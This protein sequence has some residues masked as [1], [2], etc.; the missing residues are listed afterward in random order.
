MNYVAVG[1]TLSPTSLTIEEG[2]TKT[3][4]VKLTGQP[5]KDRTVNLSSNNSDVTVDVDPDTTGNQTT[6]TFTAENWNAEQ[7]VTVAAAHDTD[8]TDDTA[9]ISLTGTGITAGTVTVNVADDEAVGLTLSVTELKMN[10][11]STATFTVKLAEQFGDRTLTLQSSNSDVIVDTD[12]STKGNQAALTF[13]A[14][15]WNTAKTVTLTAAE[16]DDGA[17]DSATI[18]LTGDRITTVPLK[19]TV[20]DN[21]RELIL[22]ETLLRLT[23]GESG[24]FRVKLSH[25][26]PKNVTVT[27]TQP[28]NTDVTVDTDTIKAGN[29]NTLLFTKLNWS[30]YQTVQVSAAADLDT[31]NE[32]ASILLT[33]V[34][35]GFVT[36]TGTVT[37]KVKD[38]PFLV[39]T[40]KLTLVEGTSVTFTVQLGTPPSQGFFVTEDF[41]LWLNPAFTFDAD[42]DTPGNQTNLPFTS[43]NWSTPQTVTVRAAHDTNRTDE[44]GILYVLTLDQSSIKELRVLVL[45]DDIGMTLSATSLV[46]DEGSSKTFTVQLA[47]Q[48]GNERTITLSSTNSDI[49]FS[50]AKLS[51]SA[52]NVAQTV[53]LRAANDPNKTDD[54]ATI[55]LR[56]AGVTSA[57]LPVTVIDDDDSAVGLTLSKSTLT[58]IE[59]ASGTFTV[60]LAKQP[61]N[62]RTVS[63]AS[64]NSEVTLDST[65]LIF[66]TSNWNVAQTVT[67]RGAQDSDKT[68]DST[69]ISLT[70]DRITA[71]SLAVTVM[72]D[73]DSAVGL[74]AS[75]TSLELVEEGASG[76]FELRLAAKP[77]N[78]RSIAL[79]V[80]G[81][82]TVSPATLSFIGGDSGNWN[83]GQTVTVSAT[84]DADKNDETATVN[85][86]GDPAIENLAGISRITA[87]SLPVSITDNDDTAVGL[88]LSPAPPASLTVVEGASGT[89]TVKLAAKPAKGRTVSLAVSGSP[90]VTVDT[91]ATKDGNQNTLTFTTANWNTAQ[92]VTVR[93]AEDADGADDTANISLTGDRIT[94]ASLAV[95]V[96]DNDRGLSVSTTALTVP[97][98]DSRTFTV[99]LATQPSDTVTVTLA[100]PTD[101]PNADITVA[102]TD[103][104]TAGTQNTLTFTTAN[105]NTA[106]TVTVKA[107]DDADALRDTATINLSASGGDYTDE[108]ATVTVTVTENDTAGLA[109]VQATDPLAVIEGS[110]ATF[111]VALA[112]QP[113]AEVTV[114]LAQPANT[115]VTVDTKTG[116]DGNQNTLT[117]TTSNWNTAKMV[118]VKA[119][120]DADGSDDSATISL[121]ADGGDYGSVTGSVSVRV[122]DN[123][124]GVTVS[125]ASLTIVEGSSD[126]FTVKLAAQPG[127]NVTVTLA[128]PTDSINADVT[129][130]TDPDAANNQSTL[131][132]TTSTWNTAQRVTVRAAEDADGIDDSAT[133]NVSATGDGYG[134]ANK[135]DVSVG[136]TD[137]DRGLTVSATSLTMPEGSSGSFKVKLAAAP[138][139]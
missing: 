68:D 13:A 125:K 106:Q 90:D 12:P 70:G 116:T 85:W 88:T 5:R 114:T 122:T 74:T 54:T 87:G 113:S 19:V 58:V 128:Q 37:V 120:E 97:E 7:T 111:T 102:D 28:G 56:G 127:S 26:P 137:N 15:E 77:A 83:T 117:F 129:F 10:E 126:T 59:G 17:D 20:T 81:D 94:T 118:T 132:F 108:T 92:T 46:M 3:F 60:Q 72:D 55:N 123:D 110:S 57:S 80:T 23:E 35:E 50:P 42:P 30:S 78:N 119:A 99:A 135:V 130:D 64:N 16:D 73:D 18:S 40:D 51:F 53:T 89:F 32:R 76:T 6:L 69:T 31:D 84:G 24:S 91:D 21:D 136:V 105:W 95:T 103:T 138:S 48:P 22:S 27:L 121:T 79:S 93:A 47:H 44:S 67:V 75:P 86:A 14:A 41:D 62:G 100:Q 139:A 1:L 65:K 43:S 25:Q 39:S 61:A 38:S 82:L 52:S 34:G 8:K 2:N 29:Q 4:K 101:N 49:T 36:K 96:T 98:N 109:I 124:R 33:A 107:A 115:D 133:I 112:T 63:L 131:T 45:D 66:T 9:K 71:G 11:G 134:V 104:G